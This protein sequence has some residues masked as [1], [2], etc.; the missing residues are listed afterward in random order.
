MAELPFQPRCVNYTYQ[1]DSPL[2][3]MQ[4][5]L[6]ILGWSRVTFPSEDFED[7]APEGGWT[8]LE[9]SDE[10]EM[11]WEADSSLDAVVDESMQ[12]DIGT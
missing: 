7:V 9:G 1:T 4:A 3:I 11:W 10:D 12:L 5:K 8:T 6:G 2:M